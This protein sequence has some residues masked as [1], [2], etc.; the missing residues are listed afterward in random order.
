MLVRGRTTSSLVSP[1]VLVL[2]D[3]KGTVGELLDL[4]RLA[5][6]EEFLEGLALVRR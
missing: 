4:S 1:G 6:G 3:P 2:K 5:H